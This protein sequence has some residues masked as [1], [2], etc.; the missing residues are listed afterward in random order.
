MNI[1]HIKYF[2]CK[3]R[4]ISLIN[5]FRTQDDVKK[6]VSI[7]AIF[8]LVTTTRKKA[9]KTPKISKTTETVGTTRGHENSKGGEY[10]KTILTQVLYIWY[11]ITFWKK[12][13]LVL[14]NL[15]NEL[16]VIRPIL[17]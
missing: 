3:K 6:L 1:F 16:N 12:S 7:L 17:A 11:S 9:F 15:S 2:N 10:P 4:G 13:V 8:T 14:F 5:I